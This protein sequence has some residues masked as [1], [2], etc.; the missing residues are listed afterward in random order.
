MSSHD[1]HLTYEDFV[2]R[3]LNVLKSH[4]KV[5]PT[6]VTLPSALLPLHISS[7]Q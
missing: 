3:V 5:D 6:K 2:D 1:G 4:P 7:C